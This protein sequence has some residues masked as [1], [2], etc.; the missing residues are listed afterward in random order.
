M[1]FLCFNLLKYRNIFNRYQ[2][3]MI[4]KNHRHCWHLKV[5]LSS[6]APEGLLIRRNKSVGYGFPPGPIYCGFKN[7]Y[8]IP[9]VN[10]P[11]GAVW[12]KIW[13]NIEYNGN[14]ICEKVIVQDNI[15]TGECK[16]PAR[17]EVFSKPSPLL[18]DR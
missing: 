14:N 3:T 12:H 4:K 10:D 7:I 18:N 13:M 5:F 15:T 8:K 1:G 11:D 17:Q 2:T 16:V 6:S 9:V